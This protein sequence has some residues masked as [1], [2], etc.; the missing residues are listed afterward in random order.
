MR[1]STVIY[2]MIFAR[3]L[4]L[5]IIRYNF[6]DFVLNVNE[7]HIYLERMYIAAIINIY[8]IYS[9]SLNKHSLN[10]SSDTTFTFV[11]FVFVTLVFVFFV[12]VILL[13]PPRTEFVSG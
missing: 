10:A 1:K 12:F 6:L 11:F 13:T 2:R 7:K 3:S 5:K 8:N 4:S 9:L